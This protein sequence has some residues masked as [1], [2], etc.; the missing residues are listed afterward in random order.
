MTSTHAGP[1]TTSFNRSQN[2]GG[3]M[4]SPQ[5]T[6]PDQMPNTA[7]VTGHSKQPSSSKELSYQY[8]ISSVH[9]ENHNRSSTAPNPVD[10]RRD[11]HDHVN[12]IHRRDRSHNSRRSASIPEANDERE[13]SNSNPLRRKVIPSPTKQQ[14]ALQGSSNFRVSENNSMSS[15]YQRIQNLR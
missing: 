11:Y 12:S 10:L 9:I 4:Y 15:I 2:P 3:T 5:I 14:E 8:P 6:T 1:P 13:R 7:M